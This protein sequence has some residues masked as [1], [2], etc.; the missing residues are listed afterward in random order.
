MLRIA[1]SSSTSGRTGTRSMTLSSGMPAS[2]K[3]LTLYMHPLLHVSGNFKR[4]D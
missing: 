4:G 2:K 1:S 3:V